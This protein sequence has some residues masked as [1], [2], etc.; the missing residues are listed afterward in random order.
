M[1]GG[2]SHTHREYPLAANRKSCPSSAVI[3]VK[4]MRTHGP[5]ADQVACLTTG[6]DRP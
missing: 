4:A 2:R 3:A 1:A 6:T 5:R